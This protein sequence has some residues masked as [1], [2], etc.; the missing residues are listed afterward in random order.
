M[1]KI[2][3]WIDEKIIVYTIDSKTKSLNYVNLFLENNHRYKQRFNN[4]VN[5]R[6]LWE[7]WKPTKMS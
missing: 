5:C 7:T 3:F 2:A 4:N 1:V 6:T